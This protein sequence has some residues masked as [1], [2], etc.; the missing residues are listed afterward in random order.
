MAKMR[1]V[2]N[3]DQSG[4]T[5]N[6]YVYLLYDTQTREIFYVGKGKG[7]RFLNHLEQA[8]KNGD[9]TVESKKCQ[10]IQQIGQKRFGCSILR[11]NLSQ[12][13]A[14]NVEAATIDLLRAK[15]YANIKKDI[16][17]VQSGHGYMTK[18]LIDIKKFIIMEKKYVQLIRS[19]CLLCLNIKH[20]DII[21]SSSL[22]QIV[23]N[24]RW[25]VKEEEAKKATY[26]VIECE[27][28]A[29]AIFKSDCWKSNPDGKTCMFNGKKTNFPQSTLDRLESHKLPKR[30]QGTPQARYIN[31]TD[32]QIAK[33]SRHI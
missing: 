23:R 14:Y 2:Q 10:K 31:Y 29:I 19:E 18:G 3:H 24:K 30:K 13:E 7:K 1:K 33:H 6:Y 9:K 8:Q 21:N 25:K 15:N 4:L 17:N 12:N 27:N 26:T 22:L 16:L 11:R 20:E 5:N 32:I 28:V